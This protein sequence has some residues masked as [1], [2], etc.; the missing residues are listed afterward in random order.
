MKRQI[1]LLIVFFCLPVEVFSALSSVHLLR[2]KKLKKDVLIFCD[3]TFPRENGVAELD[4]MGI[5]EEIMGNK[6][7]PKNRANRV[8]AL[9]GVCDDS[10]ENRK[11][12]SFV[13][14]LGSTINGNFP[15]SFAC[16]SKSIDY[17]CVDYK[18][19]MR[20][21]DMEDLVAE[22]YKDS[23]LLLTSGPE[24]YVIIRRGEKTESKFKIKNIQKGLGID[25][26]FYSEIIDNWREGIKRAGAGN[27][28]VTKECCI[29]K[30][31]AGLDFMYKP[32]T[33]AYPLSY[34]HNFTMWFERLIFSI[35]PTMLTLPL[36]QYS[37]LYNKFILT[38]RAIS[39]F[40]TVK[41]L[42]ELGYEPVC[43][44]GNCDR[45]WHKFG[46]INATR[47]PL[48]VEALKQSVNDSDAILKEIKSLAGDNIPRAVIRALLLNFTDRCN[49]CERG[50]ARFWCHN[51]KIPVYCGKDC[52]VKDWKKHKIFCNI[53]N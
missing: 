18:R 22:I 38:C 37:H 29:G 28:L 20:S 1:I 9:L 30:L 13:S 21:E 50:K 31:S 8:L 16:S 43:S 2:N 53:K 32:F 23:D 3:S 12:P 24:N 10:C 44:I 15:C 40:T 34:L 4:Y 35:Q 41:L 27:L 14:M 42:G 17:L 19:Y 45:L 26:K 52:Q 25:E 47:S 39:V 11:S 33:G 48:F 46:R 5:F 51:C 36:L 6:Y 49:Y 7:A